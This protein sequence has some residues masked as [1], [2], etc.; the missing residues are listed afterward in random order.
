MFV[1]RSCSPRRRAA[2][3]SWCRSRPFSATSAATRVALVG[4]GQQGRAAQRHGR[5]HLATDWV[6]TAGLNAGDKVITQGLG[7]LKHRRAESGRCP[8]SAP[9]QVGRAAGRRAVRPA[10]APRLSACRASSSTARSSPGC[11]AI[12]I[13]LAG[14]RRDPL[15]ADRA[16]SRHRA[17]TG[18][19]PREL[20]RRVGRDAGEQR[21]P[22]HRA[23]AD[24]HRRPALFLARRRARAGQV[25]ITVN[26]RQGHRS[27]HRAGP[28]PEQGPAG[29]LAAA[30]AGAAAGRRRHQVESRLP[31]DRRRS[32]TTTNQRTNIDV[33]DYLVVQPAGPARARRRASATSTCSARNTPCASGST[34]ASC[35][36]LRA[37]AR[38]T[39][40]PRSRRRT[41]RSR[42]A[43]SAACRRPPA[44][45]STRR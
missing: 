12:V 3:R 45:C 31:A 42:P 18:Q 7:K 26:V 16:I 20:S 6:V 13:M 37:D 23:A 33:S 22:D 19:H 5:P 28:G 10:A 29:A 25:S 44:R 21:H 35:R 17:A 24:R 30:A 43:K 4:P 36:Q 14:H 34:R 27:R 9:Q 40:S 8:Q 11:I 1:Q 32:T 39:S 15:A 41:P 2:T 38:A